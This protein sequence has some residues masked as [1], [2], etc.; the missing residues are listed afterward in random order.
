MELSGVVSLVTGA[1]SGIG[2]ATALALARDGADVVVCDVDGPAAEAC[3]REIEAASRRALVIE[4]DVGR[5]ADVEGMVERAIAWQGRCDLFVSN[6]GIGCRGP[7]HEFSVADWEDVLAI[8]LWASIW[9]VRL[10]VPHMLE[11]GTGRLAF[12]ASG[13]G[14][15]GFDG[16]APYNVAKFGLVGLA[17]SLARQLKG[18]RVGVSI[19]VPG[20]VATGGWKIYRFA[21]NER[22]SDEEIERRRS[23]V[24]DEGKGWPSPESMAAAIVDGLRSDRVYI[25]QKHPTMDDWYGYLMRRRADD[26]DGFVLGEQES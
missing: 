18:T 10:L 4:A 13:A 9:A 23:A 2:R 1:A 22:M 17:E 16:F 15:E 6:A 19:I 11:R 3:G 24:R 26:P 25:L 8:D 14:L 20:A 5:R 7:A 21:G 12:V